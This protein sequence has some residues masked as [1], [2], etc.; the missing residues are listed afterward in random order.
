MNRK[1]KVLCLD[2]EGTLISNAVSQ[3]PRPFL[4]EFL[5]G[6]EVLF[7]RIAMYTS[8]PESTF[9]TIAA[10]LV[11]EGVVPAWFQA[12]EYIDWEGPVKDLAF[13]GEVAPDEVILVDD[14]DLVVH[15]A[16][17]CQWIR[18]EPFVAPYSAS[19]TEL[20][21]VLGELKRRLDVG[22]PN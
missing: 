9:R 20:K 14:I 5:D 8:V 11:S 10:L 3:L 4:K 2:L 17:R 6:C 7:E 15:P 12:V 13:V 19:D 18:V 16:Q 21:R 1:P 22:K